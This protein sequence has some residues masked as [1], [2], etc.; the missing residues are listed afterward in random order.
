MTA[1]FS[2]NTGGRFY[3][4]VGVLIVLMSVM[5]FAPVL[6]WAQDSPPTDSS[7]CPVGSTPQWKF[8]GP[9]EGQQEKC[10]DAAGNIVGTP[11][12][13]PT[14]CN[15]LI[16][17][18]L[19]PIVCIG[20]ALSAF[21]AGSLVFLTS[22]V[23][24]VSGM[25]FDWL[26]DNTVV[27][28]GDAVYTAGVRTAVETAWTAFRD[29]ANIIIIG[30]FTFI[31]ISIILGLKEF[32]QKKL[33]A[34][35]L[36]IAILIN[37][38]L[39]FTKVIVDASNFTARQ[40]YTASTGQAF[41]ASSNTGQTQS[42][43][44]AG[45]FMRYAGVSGFKDTFAATRQLADNL[46]NGFIALLHGVFAAILLLGAAL[47]LFYGSFLLISRTLLIIFLMITASIAFASYL[48]PK[49]ASSSYGWSTWWSSLIKSAV[50]APILMFFL[51]ATLT[52]AAALKQSGGTLGDLVANPTKATDLAALFNYIIVLGLLFISFK[53]SS[54]FA[55]KIAGFNFASFAPA[56]AAGFGARAVGILGR[57][58][59]GRPALN[60][61][62]RLQERAA[63]AAQD[64]RS[65]TAG[66]YDFTAQQFRR[67]AKRDFN[68]MRTPLGTAIQQTAGIKKLD[69]LA[70]AT[71]KG[72]EG[73]QDAYKK[74]MA[75]A[76]RR[77]TVTKIDQD[78]AEK[79]AVRKQALESPALARDHEAAR[80]MLE[81][82]TGEQRH[83]EE[84]MAKI[85]DG[86]AGQMKTMLD[87]L[88]RTRQTS[89]SGSAEAQRVEREI[90]AARKNQKEQIL[91]QNVRIKNASE[92]TERAQREQGRIYENL[93]EAAIQSGKIPR[94]Y[95]EAG[96]IAENLTKE[97]FTS[98]LFKASGLSAKSNEKFAKEVAREAGKQQRQ[99][100]VKDEFGPALKDFTKD[101]ESHAPAAPAAPTKDA[102]GE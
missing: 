97:S 47:V 99:Q 68:A 5:L 81:T 20:R 26:I 32:G 18:F 94:E 60:V 25:L 74:R 67:A 93:K 2:R 27:R 57:Q 51:W 79:D 53:L 40:I 12:A 38:S 55:G 3:F 62:Q 87:K 31:A 98:A 24:T 92:L 10:V 54:T 52:V 89:G 16:N 70:G 41:S 44:I 88:D 102:A 58:F 9:V 28:F 35:V 76:T 8:T 59:I 101:D 46:D 61:S 64:G 37:F 77:M 30:I 1:H 91:E 50:L 34:N 66:L 83:H 33:I 95:K 48:V 19:S 15:S 11:A 49:W 100:R 42:Y 43:D 7:R 39:L 6:V 69:T 96:E 22:W 56:L 85:Q 29:I 72:F 17:F 80:K 90:V 36:I 86:F 78:A 65:R 23:L 84:Q 13:G 45:A 63:R 4:I 71:V 73:S 75:E 14:S 21:I 82:A